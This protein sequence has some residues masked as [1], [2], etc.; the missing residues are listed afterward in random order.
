MVGLLDRNS[1]I[2]NC[3]LICAMLIASCI[4]VFHVPIVGQHSAYSFSLET[5]S[6]PVDSQIDVHDQSQIAAVIRQVLWRDRLAIGRQACWYVNDD[7]PLPGKTI[8]AKEMMILA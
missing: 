6:I 7:T 3:G 8:V 5:A 2:R 4:S 1:R